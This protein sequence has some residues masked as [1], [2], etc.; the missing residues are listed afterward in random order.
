L[1]LLRLHTAEAE[2]AAA[3]SRAS[4]LDRQRELAALRHSPAAVQPA[5][6]SA[7][8]TQVQPAATAKPVQ[9]QSPTPTPTTQPMPAGI[10]PQQISEM[11][12]LI[13]ELFTARVEATEWLT[14][15]CGN[16][17]P[18][19]YN[20]TEAMGVLSALYKLK[21][22][23]Q[24]AAVVP[25]I[26]VDDRVQRFK[27]LLP[28]SGIDAAKLKAAMAQHGAERF[29]E[30]SEQHQDA[31]LAVLQKAADAKAATENEPPFDPGPTSGHR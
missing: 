21:A 1:Q 31:L 3:V 29:T 10:T 30:L 17:D 28:A 5:G 19:T 15:N 7:V 18:Q 14:T 22:D 20:E 4:L 16:G 13:K 27:E 8:Q 9:H 24:M 2:A 11:G 23:R 6:Q 25:P 12:S 26:A